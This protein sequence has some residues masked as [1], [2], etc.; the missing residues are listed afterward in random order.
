MA[1]IML[2]SRIYR[3]TGLTPLLGSAPASRAVR[4]QFIA[5]KAPT[6]ELV[7]EESEAP[8][9]LDEKGL[10]VFNR[11]KL[12]HPCLMA[13]QV[14]GFFKAALLALKT[15]CKVVAP[16]AKVDTLLFVEPRFIP[17][18]RDDVAIKE[19]DT[20]LERPLRAQTAQG[21]RIA[22]TASEQIDDPW[23]IDIEISLLPSEATAK[24][25]ALSWDIVETALSY[26]AYRGLGQWRNADYGRFT[27]RRLD[28]N[29]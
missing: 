23:Y 10:T 3:L 18:L 8:F 19:E 7:E 2:E 4:T 28:G 15:Q 12:D 24:G 6:P 20:I 11:D 17:L 13:Y 16:K 29:E 14:K 22:L 21:E 26:G 5:S 9:D 1:E 27:W 25:K